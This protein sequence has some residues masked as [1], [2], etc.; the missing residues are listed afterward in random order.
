VWASVPTAAIAASN[1]GKL[2]EDVS[3][4]NVSVNSD[5]TISLPS[6]IQPTA[7]GTPIGIV[8]DADGTVTSALLGAGA[9]GQCPYNAVFGGSDSY[10]SLASYQHALIGI[11]GQCA[12]QSSQLTDVKYRLVRM[13]GNVLGL[14]WS[15]LN[16]NVQ[17]G[18]PL[19]T[20]DDFA[21]FPV[22]HFVDVWNCVPITLCDPNPYQLSMD[23]VAALSRLYPVTEQNQSQFPG[24]EVFSATT[25][26]IHGS[27]HFTD[28]HGNRAQPMQ[29]VNVVARWIDPATGKPSRRYAVS[30]VSGFRFRGNAGNVITGFVDSVGDDFAEWGSTD[31]SLEGYF[32]LAGLIPPPTGA[33]YQLAV[34]AL[35]PQWSAGVGGMC[36]GR[37]R[38]RA[39]LRRLRSQSCRVAMSSKTS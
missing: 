14:G 8:Y 36:R 37:W 3:G 7:I 27:V 19:P 6:D 9:G 17:T 31:L 4:I 29:G 22:M 24:K 12:Q 2:A 26:R 16:V 39:W 28:S 23:D 21:G 34:E 20:S 30:S 15:Q 11:N 10:G 25:A 5:G 13:I 35:D 18:S 33:Q 1:T 32:D 38:H